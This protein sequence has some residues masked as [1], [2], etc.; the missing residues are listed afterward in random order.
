[1]NSQLAQKLENKLREKCPV[2]SGQLR[3]SIQMRQLDARNWEVIIGNASGNMNGTPSER[4]ASITNFSVT[5]GINKKPNPN[6]HWV[7][8]AIKEWA[9][10]NMFQFQLNNGGENDE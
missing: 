10:E 6:Y 3:A 2:D 9:T 7:N 4:Y 8:N 1:M 5:L